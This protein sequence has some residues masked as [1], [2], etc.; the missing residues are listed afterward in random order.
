MHAMLATADPSVTAASDAVTGYITD[1][2]AAI[3]AVI[4][5]LAALAWGLRFVSR[6]VRHLG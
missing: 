4:L 1:N 5:T 3:F 6:K 2:S